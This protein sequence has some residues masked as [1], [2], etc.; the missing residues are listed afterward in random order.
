MTGAGGTRRAASAIMA[1]I[2]GR[3]AGPGAAGNPLMTTASARTILIIAGPNGAGKTT[4]AREFLRHEAGFTAF[5]NADLIAEGLNPIQP[6]DAAFAAGRMM[7][8]L[9]R[10][11]VSA[12]RSFAFETT[13]SGR[14]YARM[15]PQW[16]A[17]G[18][19]VRLFFLRLPTPEMAV[20]RVQ[21]R[22]ATGGHSIPE[23]TIRRRF[24]AGLRN[25]ERIYRAL[26]D[27]WALYDGASS[28][29]RLLARG[30]M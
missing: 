25:F 26:V 20:A 12:V 7:L 6:E 27:E 16:R 22:V 29:P 1:D 4:F 24:D 18:Y 19:R 23:E 10:N 3:A 11:Y 30:R 15:I 14:A 28:P 9:I 21:K 5:V 8:D 17:Q 2:R 13:L